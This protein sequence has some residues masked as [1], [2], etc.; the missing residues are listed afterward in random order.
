M[1]REGDVGEVEVADCIV[2][3]REVGWIAGEELG[4]L[5]AS[6]IGSIKSRFCRETY[7]DLLLQVFLEL[8]VFYL[9]CPPCGEVCRR[10]SGKGG[11]ILVI[12][13]HQ[14]FGASR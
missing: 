5:L 12:C 13:F 1:G 11:R 14:L 4:E 3:L 2:V 9:R 10:Y 6:Y 8:E 7:I